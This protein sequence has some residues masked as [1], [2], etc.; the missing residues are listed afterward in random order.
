[1]ADLNLATSKYHI[2]LYIYFLLLPIF[3]NLF[4][5]N[6]MRQENINLFIPIIEAGHSER[7]DFLSFSLI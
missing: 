2:D 3:L 6:H 7:L 4:E 1:M 5:F